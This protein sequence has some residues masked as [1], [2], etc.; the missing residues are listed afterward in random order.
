MAENMGSV[1]LETRG[2]IAVVTLDRPA[3]LNALTPFMLSELARIADEIEEHPALRAV[4]LTAGGERA[5]CVGADIKVWSS[6][7]ALDMWRNWVRKGHRVFDRWATLRVPVIAAINGHAFGGGLELLATCDI[8]VTDP[9]ATFALPEAGIATCPG[10]SGTQRLVQLIGPG[11][12]KYMALTGI[13]IN[14]DRAYEMGLVQEISEPGNV[15]ATAIAL[16][17][18]ISEQAPVSVQLTRQIIDAGAGTDTAMALESIA[19]ALAA[20]TRDAKEGLASFSERR[21][22]EYLGE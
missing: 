17:E 2:T 8:R 16:A 10:W 21:K 20:T 9:A 1:T 3:K 22:A 18:K 14:A 7:E 6:L 12:V 5:F 13:R 11:Q 15:L 19:G 4:V